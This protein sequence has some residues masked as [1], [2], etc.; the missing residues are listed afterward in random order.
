M[1]TKEEILDEA[2][3]NSTLYSEITKDERRIILKAM[4][5]YADQSQEPKQSE[6]S[7]AVEFVEWCVINANP[8]FPNK[9]Q[10]KDKLGFEL[11]TQQ[12]YDIFKSKSTNVKQPTIYKE[13]EWGDKEEIDSDN[14]KYNDPNDPDSFTTDTG[15]NP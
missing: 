15:C 8:V 9:G 11:T 13:T 5:E 4:Q 14:P 6:V 1:R 2:I 12:L 10:W 7:E 3:D